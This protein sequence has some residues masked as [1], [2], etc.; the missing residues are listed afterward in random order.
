[1]SRT[2]T[3]LWFNDEKGYGFIRM[4]GINEDAFVHARELGI[5]VT[6]RKGQQV[7]FDACQGRKGWRAT[8]VRLT[9]KPIQHT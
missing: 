9:S 2:G 6:L 3:V 1:M 7:T 5:G 8:G 4:D